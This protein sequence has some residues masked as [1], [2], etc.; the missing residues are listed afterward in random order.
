[1]SHSWTD[2]F[3]MWDSVQQ[4]DCLLVWAT[5]PVQPKITSSRRGKLCVTQTAD[6][7]VH[8]I[9]GFLSHST[10]PLSGIALLIHFT[11]CGPVFLWK[12]PSSKCCIS[13]SSKPGT[14]SF[15]KHFPSGSPKNLDR[16]II[17]LE[18][19]FQLVR[20]LVSFGRNF[21]MS[22]NGFSTQML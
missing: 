18:E 14:F 11:K 2:T 17:L 6:C 10:H 22:I 9:A 21:Q 1:M 12:S 7:K 15:T 4:R 3:N 13:H 19:V 20:Q 5:S 16:R 8:V